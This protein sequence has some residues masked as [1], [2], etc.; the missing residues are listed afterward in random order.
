MKL[1]GYPI[2]P[3]VRRVAACLEEKGLPYEFVF[4]DLSTGQQK[5]EPFISL[6]PFGQVPVLED[7][8]LKLFE[9]RAITQYIARAYAD[10]GTPLLPTDPLKQTMV[11]VWSE[12]ESHAFDAAAAKLSFEILI[13]P[14]LGMSTD[15]GAV[16]VQQGKLAQV[17]DVYES[18]LGKSK[19]LG[20]EDFSLADL[21][22]IPIIN[23]LL[24]TKIK[25][26]FDARPH[27]SAWCADI[28]ARPAWQK[29]KMAIKVHG[30]L[31]STAA[32]RVF[33]CLNE[34]GLEYEFVPVDMR[35]GEHKKEPFLS[36]N[37]FGQVPAFEDGDLKL[38][39]SRAVNQYIAHAYADKGNPLIY[40]DP[41]KMA[42][43]SL[44]MEV[45]A[46][47]YDP[48]ATKLT[49]ELSIKPLMGMSTDDTVVEEQEV[50]L[51]KVLDVYE[52]RLA[53]SKYLGGDSFSLADL[54]HLPTMN[55]LM[56]TRVKAVF[57]AYP[58]VS[59]WYADIS[60]RPAW[61]K[62]VA[63]KNNQ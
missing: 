41:K 16:G 15:E 5:K 7:G 55:Y 19:Y 8:D 60:A 30:S 43:V 24:G 26:L 20:G 34:K 11:S 57:D 46:H 2:S 33:A 37:P 52:A 17:L 32:M 13:K 28:L 50:Q 1:H 4:V 22:H 27:V 12:V 10:K 49:W 25:A 48:P 45:E 35:A 14:I 59:S 61:Q 38:F 31:F 40:Q 47:K 39:E 29:H 36:L 23:N 9:S 42:I 63:V 6:N 53:Q 44:W 3:A 54:H 21:H 51:A 58:H 56:G 62:V 18:R